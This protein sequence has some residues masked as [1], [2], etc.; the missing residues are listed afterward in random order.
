MMGPGGTSAMS[1]TPAGETP[2]DRVAP[3]RRPSGRPA[4]HQRWDNLLF[5]HWSFDPA[6]IQAT[7]P[8]GVRVDTFDGRAWVGVVP[9]EM[10]RVRPWGLPP[11]PGISNFPELNVRT[12]VIDPEGVPGVW[13]YSL[14]A[15]QGLAV[16][17]ARSRFHLPYHRARMSSVYDAATQRVTYQSRRRGADTDD[18]FRYRRVGTQ[19]RAALGSLEW[20]LVER[21]AFVCEKASV[22]LFR[23]R[24][25]H[26]PYP[27]LEVELECCETDLF[28]L[29]GLPQPDGPP[30]HVLASPGVQ[31]EAFKVEGPLIRVRGSNVA[32]GAVRGAKRR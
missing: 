31:V 23:G 4:L 20:F 5:V 12:Y 11:M 26:P 3:L 6:L 27:L 22:G 13:F 9:F 17:I 21:Y 24:V 29:D 28:A 8:D 16:R 10:R 7:L 1:T 15:D 18:R 14:D 19:H 30:E 25:H 2:L 32:S